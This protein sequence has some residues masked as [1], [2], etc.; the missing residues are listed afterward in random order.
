MKLTCIS[1]LAL[2][3]F[4]A[5]VQPQTYM[6]NPE[7]H[8]VR[9]LSDQRIVMLADFAHEFPLPYHTLTS[10]L[11]TWLTMLEKGESDQ[12]RVTLFLEEDSRTA[13][14]V[15]HYL[16]TG[17]L[18]SLLDF[19]LPTTSLERLEFYSDLRR[20][21]ARIDSMNAVRPSSQAISFNVQ[22]PEAMN[23]FDPRLI[24]SS[25]TASLLFFVRDRDS[26]TAM[27]IRAYLQNHPDQKGLIFYGAGHLIKNIV[28]KAFTQSLRPEER[29]GAFLARYLKDEYGDSQVFVVNQVWKGRSSLNLDQFGSKDVMILSGDVPWKESPPKDENVDPRNFDAFIIRNE[30]A[31][32]PHFLSH[33]F[34]KRIVTASIKR[35]RQMEN[36]R[37]GEFGSRFYNQALKGLTF[38]SD[39]SF[40]SPEDWNS[41]C[42]TYYFDGLARLQS[43]EFRHRLANEFFQKREVDLSYLQDLEDFGFGPRFGNPKTMS[44]DEWN[45]AFDRIWPEIVFVNAVGIYWV[46]DAKEV[47][48]AKS[49]LV[50]ASGQNYDDAARYLKWWRQRFCGVDY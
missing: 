6:S 14:L 35:L 21:T 2:F 50:E 37:S 13:S 41:W 36:H 7:E 49:Y 40:L 29:T 27:N 10:T 8:I 45:K 1:V 20:I 9:K 30:P 25:A 33:V 17:D 16:E 15:R 34:S 47:A 38:L 12:R 32:S 19:V 4:A 43:A 31:A 3:S 46:G 28:T 44:H 26:L 18:D 48:Q 11:S 23:A 5:C 42:S 24:D 39:T 22:G